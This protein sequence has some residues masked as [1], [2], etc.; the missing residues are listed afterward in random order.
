MSL[1]EIT[2]LAGR[3]ASMIVPMDVDEDGRMDIIVQ[4]FTSDP[5]D[6]AG[7]ITV[8]YNNYIFDAFY[9]TAMMI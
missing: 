9:L 7:A 3:T 4:K 5:S 1:P 8:I 2:K 6:P